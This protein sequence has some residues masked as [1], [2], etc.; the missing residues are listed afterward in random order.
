MGKTQRG[1]WGFILRNTSDWNLKK[2]LP[3][4]RFE[5]LNLNLNFQVT[6]EI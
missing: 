2:N 4:F 3:E 6:N 5:N 1:Q